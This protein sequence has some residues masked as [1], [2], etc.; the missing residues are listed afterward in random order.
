MFD[1]L[2]ST[3]DSE[4]GAKLPHSPLQKLEA[5]EFETELWYSHCA[6]ISATDLYKEDGPAGDGGQEE[7]AGLAEQTGEIKQE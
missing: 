3:V 5:V 2:F 4:S 6:D 7:A 1:F